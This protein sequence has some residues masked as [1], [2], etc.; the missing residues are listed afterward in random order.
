M[1]ILWFLVFFI[2]TALHFSEVYTLWKIFKTTPI[3]DYVIGTYFM[4]VEV[5]MI[6]LSNHPGLKSKTLGKIGQMALGIYAI[7][8]IFVDLLRPIDKV[9]DSII[10]EV[11]YVVVVLL[12]SIVTSLLLSQ[13]KITKKIIV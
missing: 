2:G 3:Q 11:I 9:T 8:V 6:A 10:W 1:V 13:N 12:L 7:H 5:A 4:G